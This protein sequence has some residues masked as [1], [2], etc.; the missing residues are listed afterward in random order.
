MKAY[1]CQ[2]CV[3]TGCVR[4]IKLSHDS[5]WLQDLLVV[6]I[7]FFCATNILFYKFLFWKTFH[8]RVA[9]DRT[10]S[11]HS[12]LTASFPDINILHNYCKVSN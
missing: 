2:H 10:E 12:S 8:V 9:K 1:V 4:T 11:H 7:N 3:R 5:H 6:A